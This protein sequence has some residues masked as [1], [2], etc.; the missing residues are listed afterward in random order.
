MKSMFIFNPQSGKGSVVRN[1]EYILRNLS[2]KFGEIEERPTSY[3]KE[4]TELAAKAASEGYDYLFVAGGD[5]TLNE[6]INGLAT[7]EKTPIIGYIPTGTVNDLARS[8][9]IPRNIKGAVKNILEGDILE[10]DIFKVN[11]RYG[12]YVCC[13]G[14]FTAPSYSA[15]RESKKV[16]GKIAYFI[17]GAKD[18]FKAKPVEVTLET[19]DE[20]ITKKCALVLILNSR[21]TAGFLL[22]RK[23]TLDDGEVEVVLVHSHKK[24]ILLSDI[25]RIGDMFALGIDRYKKSRYVTYRKLSKFSLKLGGGVAINLD[26]EKSGMG[27]FDFEVINRAVRIIVPTKKI[28]VRHK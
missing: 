22:N 12:I 1:K 4:A 11:D 3:A 2:Q 15:P 7:F 17:D 10:H 21:S 20:K 6:V 28:K 14:L 16:L 8:L 27:N 26:G 24:Y 5:G 23:A 13:A 9:S 19:E 18:L 25:L